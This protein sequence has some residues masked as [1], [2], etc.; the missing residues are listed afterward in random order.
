[1]M[2]VPF[3]GLRRFSAAFFLW[4][5]MNKNQKSGGKAPQSKKANLHLTPQ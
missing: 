3:L 1:M 2:L 5:S 4:F